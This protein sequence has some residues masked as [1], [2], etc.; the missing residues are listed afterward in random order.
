MRLFESEAIFNV[1]A[2]IWEES[3]F[4][5]GEEVEFEEYFE[6]QELE[7]ELENE[8]LREEK[9]CCECCDCCEFEEITIGEL[10]DTYVERFEEGCNCSVCVRDL[11]TELIC[12]I[13]EWIE[14]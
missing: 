7:V 3:Y 11:L 8:K 2:G 9:C 6:Q 13:L 10:I 12:D 5:D 1:E 14:D 4:I